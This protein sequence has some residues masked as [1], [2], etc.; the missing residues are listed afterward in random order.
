[1]ETIRP[2]RFTNAKQ[3][4]VEARYTYFIPHDVETAAI[5]PAD[6]V[7]LCFEW[8]PPTEKYEAER[9]WVIVRSV[10]P[11]VIA[12]DLDNHPFEKGKME[13]GERVLFHRDNILSIRWADPEPELD[14]PEVRQYWERCLVDSCVLDGTAPVEYIYREE[15]DMA[16]EGDEEPDSGWRIRGHRAG[17]T[18]AEMDE[19]SPQYVAIGAVLNRDD[20]WLHLIDEPIGSRFIRDFETGKYTPTD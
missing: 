19:R 2:V 3:R 18:D 14:V 6:L 17:A 10:G 9:M 16:Q 4:A 11:D 13:A 12:G 5:R 1:M 20:S 8:D 7:K 15:P